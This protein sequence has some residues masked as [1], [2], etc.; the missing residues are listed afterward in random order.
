MGVKPWVWAGLV[1]VAVGVTANARAQSP[2]TETRCEAKVFEA[3][4]LMSRA[5][6][7]LERC[8]S[9]A[10]A[11]ADLKTTRDAIR[12]IVQRSLMPGDRGPCGPGPIRSLNVEFRSAELLDV[13]IGAVD[14]PAAQKLVEAQRSLIAPFRIDEHFEEPSQDCPAAP[15]AALEVVA[16]PYARREIPA[17]FLIRMLD[18]KDCGEAGARIA[19]ERAQVGQNAMQAFW[20]RSADSSSSEPVYKLCVQAMKDWEAVYP[21]SSDEAWLLLKGQQ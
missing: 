2:G 4:E 1:V 18:E 10:D 5:K 19:K 12:A 20:I 15:A 3:A 17:P 6:S 14:Q 13:R 11:T 21:A 9:A 8:L 16:K 7:R